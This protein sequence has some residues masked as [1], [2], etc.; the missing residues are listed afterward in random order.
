MEQE[1]VEMKRR[2]EALEKEL[3]ELQDKVRDLEGKVASGH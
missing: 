2:I 3:G 1:L